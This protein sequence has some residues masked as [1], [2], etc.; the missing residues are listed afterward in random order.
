VSV[1]WAK[2][3]DAIDE[4]IQRFV[5]G[6]DAA[7]DRAIFHSDI[8][9]TKAHVNGL[10]R[11]GVLSVDDAA[12][13]GACLDR[14]ADEF[15]AGTFVLDARFEDGHSAIEAYVTDALGEPGRKLHTGRSRNDQVQV[16]LRLWMKERL[17]D[18]DAANGAAADACL[19][20]ARTHEKTAMPGYTHLQRAVPSTVGHWL[21][22]FVEAF[23]DDRALARSTRDWID[24]SPIGTGAG[25]GVNLPLDR[26]GV[27]AELGFARLQRNPQY[28]QNARG[29]YELAC[30]SALGQS[31]LDVRRLAWDLSLFTTSELAFVKLPASFTTGSSLM[32]NKKNPDVVELLRAAFA[33]TAGASTEIASVLSLP[34]S[35]H[36][37]LQATK[38]PFVSAMEHGLTALSLIPRLVRGLVFDEAAMRAAI[39]PEMYATDR[40]IE[41]A[42][43][44]V[45]FR[46]AYR[47]VGND[48]APDRPRTP[49][50]SIDARVSPGGP[51]DLGLDALE[52]RLRG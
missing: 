45:P 47:S 32:P 18:L 5:A 51:G 25:F 12:A 31:L 52:A 37:D 26:E 23:I 30:L 3:A 9:A 19:E 7:V 24:A 39:S 22:G 33:R 17:S 10:G 36:R 44:G 49:E 29:K 21:A 20:V 40:A 2:G 16:A 15:T 35:Y 38:G 41:L 50:D 8:R 34:S 42:V 1:I 46:D 28:V 14:L 11:I 6:E 13:I 43:Q 27:R 48:L 4:A